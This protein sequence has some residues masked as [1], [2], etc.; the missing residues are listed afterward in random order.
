M[1]SQSGERT[2]IGTVIPPKVA[3][4]NAAISYAFA[5]EL[6]SEAII[7]GSLTA[8]LPFDFLMKS[9]GKANLHQTLDDFP[10][11]RFSLVNKCLLIRFLSLVSLTKHY[12]DLWEKCWTDEVLEDNWAKNDLRLPASFFPSLTPHWTRHCA[13]RTDYARRQVL[14]EIDVLAAMALGLTLD[15]LITI[16]RVQ[17]PVMRQYE[18][19]TWYDAGG[20]IVFTASKG[21]VGVGLPRKAGKD[22]APCTIT[23]PAG[24][25]ER[26]AVGWE[27]IREL[28]AGV[29]VARTV[30]DDT[31][32][33][34]PREKTIVY[35]APFDKCDREADYRLAWAV[36]AG[37]FDGQ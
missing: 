29:T 6:L 37:R 22:D 13:L 36:F 25:E 7:F 24:R 28:A 10:W 15:E 16:Y 23:Y 33:G 27:D 4:T 9:T 14:V 30:I 35:T 5:D 26:K 21:L 19:D 3:H 20:R 34:G 1:L 12:S 2:L 18:Q 8:S 31:L 11:I 17:F 32:P